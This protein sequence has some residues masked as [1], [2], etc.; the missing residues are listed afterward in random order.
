MNKQRI[1]IS[2]DQKAWMDTYL[3]DDSQE[4]YHQ[5]KRK[6]VI[7]C[8][9]G[10]YQFT[11]DREAEP[12]ALAFNAMG[13]HAVVL[14][15]HVDLDAVFPQPLLDLAATMI[16]VKN[17]CEDWLVDEDQVYVCGF[18]AG[19]HLAASLGVF[20][21]DSK[22]IPGYE[23]CQEK[24]KP[25]GMILGYSVIDLKSTQTKLDI[26]I[27]EGT[28]LADIPF[29]QK[30]PA[31]APEDM[32][33]VEGQKRYV[34]FEVAMNAYMFGGYATEEQIAQW[35]LQNHVSENT[36]PAFIWHGGEDG[37][38]YPRNS[39][40]FA[41]ALVE[42]NIPVEFHLFGQ[43]GHGLG[44]ANEVTGANPWDRVPACEQWIPMCKT[45]LNNRK[46]F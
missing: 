17:H 21:N 42:K 23:D 27:P 9:G 37:L 40:R 12:I 31:I 1:F 44:L 38:I 22:M 30:H 41:A 36:P 19:G 39:S 5:K 18:S 34:N 7:V 16:Y 43:G 2:E 29:G 8:P 32:F 25:A 4:F 33:V 45:W 3:L 20:W 35:S 6:L 13:H 24:L 10:A 11:S 26:G 28:P 46:P 15:Y 14:R